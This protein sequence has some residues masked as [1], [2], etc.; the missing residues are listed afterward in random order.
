[1]LGT[2][3]SI[4]IALAAILGGVGS[5][6]G[7]VVGALAL[8]V[9]EEGS[10]ALLGGSGRGTDLIVYASLIIAIAV[11]QPAGLVGWWRALLRRRE[12]RLQQRAAAREQAA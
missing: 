7:P 3:L 9:I 6:W 12:Q 10:R 1:M 4:K 2:G 8:T 11:W 5:L